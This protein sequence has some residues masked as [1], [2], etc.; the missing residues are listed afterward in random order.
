MD[1]KSVELTRT[2]KNKGIMEK[3]ERRII[4]FLKNFGYTNFEVW[5]RRTTKVNVRGIEKEI[6]V[7]ANETN[8][9]REVNRKI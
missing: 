4:G 1:I 9:V 5:K 6:K 2:I 8:P 7:K 3:N